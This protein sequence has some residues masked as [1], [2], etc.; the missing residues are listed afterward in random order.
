MSHLYLQKDFNKTNVFSY[1]Y[2]RSGRI[3]PLYLA[4][5]L[6]SYFLTTANMHI[7][8]SIPNFN[9]VLS[10]TLFL[11]GESVLWSIPAEVQFY[12]IFLIFWA[13]AKH[14]TGYIYLLIF[15]TMILLY[16]TNFPKIY[17][18][19][20]GIRYNEFN[21][22][23]TLPYFFI[24][25]IF[26]LHYSSLRIP[27]YLKKHSF[28]LVLCLIPLMYPE[29]TPIESEDKKRMWLSYEVLL[30]MSS[31]FFIVVFLVPDKNILLENKIG[32]FIGKI[33]YSLYLL[34]MPV[35]EWVDTFAIPV[36]FKLALSFTFSV[37]I[38]YVSFTFFEKPAAK[39]IREIPN[40]LASKPIYPVVE[41]ASTSDR[42]SQNQL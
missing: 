34:H 27:N 24:G 31:I 38:A 8:Y 26:G 9:T 18:N 7:L 22:L 29:F 3:L 10:H 39:I 20:F 15:S 5:V 28:I 30:I 36:E 13:L 12:F 41:T 17:G 16:L 37:V 19:I 4:V 40:K 11:Y 25:V 1:F 35:I 6:A 2:A 23:R 42:P 21:V 14:R 32:D 33:S